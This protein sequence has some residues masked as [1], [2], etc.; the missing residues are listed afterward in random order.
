MVSVIIP[1]KDRPD[2]ALRCLA[3]LTLQSVSTSQYEIIIVN[4]HSS[5]DYTLVKDFA[6]Q[7]GI[8]FLQNCGA[9][10]ACARNTGAQYAHGNILA[11][12]DDDC[13][14][15]RNWI[16]SIEMFYEG[17]DSFI[18]LA[19]GG[20][21]KPYEVN[22]H[23]VNR[24][25]SYISFLDGPIISDGVITNMATA[26]LAVLKSAFRSVSG[27]DSRMHQLGAEDQNLVY[28]LSKK[29]TL[30]F[31]NTIMVRHD[32]DITLKK[33]CK[34]YYAYGKG[35]RTHH[36]LVNVDIDESS[37]YVPIAT[38]T[39]LFILF[40][41]KIIRLAVQRVKLKKSKQIST[42]ETMVFLW[43]SFLQEVCFQYGYTKQFRE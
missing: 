5:L 14:P 39:L 8:I 22:K 34:K 13:I 3:A 12:T 9:G 17:Q 38:N 6:L 16:E 2:S 24:Y 28:R 10:P 11:F 1:T 36:Q 43:L 29:G 42:R 15:E 37:I 33:F 21:V 4:D 19:V 26:N 35:V 31:S 23:W 7:N 27:F 41:Y 40:F 18:P 25:L 20:C 32:H 30:S